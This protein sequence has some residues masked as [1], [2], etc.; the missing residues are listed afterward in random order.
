MRTDGMSSMTDVRERI[1]PIFQE[2]P[3][4]MLW[5]A[6]TGTELCKLGLAAEQTEKGMFIQVKSPVKKLAWQRAPRSVARVQ[7]NPTESSGCRHD[8]KLR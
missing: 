1:Y 7:L 4:E 5:P 6:S 2:H 3:S 8:W